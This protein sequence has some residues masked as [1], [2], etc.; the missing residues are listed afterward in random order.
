MSADL[1]PPGF[2]ALEPFVPIWALDDFQA[3]F[4]ARYDSD[5]AE[6]RPF[7][8]AM[9]P[10]ADAAL[11]ELGRQDL[12][13]LSERHAVLFKMLMSLVHVAVPVERYGQPRP[14]SVTWPAGL[15]VTQ[16]SFPA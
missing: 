10:L 3:R 6:I 9:T 13:N 2:E 12:A 15:T 8:D 11:E 16:G 7:Y 4:L 14:K 5:M 1:L